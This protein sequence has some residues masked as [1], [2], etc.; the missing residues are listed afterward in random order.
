M[1]VSVL[2]Y[3]VCFTAQPK[4][5]W[6]KTALRVP[7]QQTSPH[8]AAHRWLRPAEGAVLAVAAR[9]QTTP[10]SQSER[11]S[12]RGPSQGERGD[13]TAPYL[14]Y[15]QIPHR[16]PVSFFSPYLAFFITLIVRYSSFQL[17]LSFCFWR[18]FWKKT[19]EKFRNAKPWALLRIFLEAFCT[20]VIEP[21]H[22]KKKKS[23]HK[24]CF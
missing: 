8:Q 5:L 10:L 1:K 7:A 22:V 9:D 18:T 21:V 16:S 13:Q 24:W 20:G 19:N 23:G 12:A 17:F 14:F 6:R 11:S 3:T 15:L 2:I 4:L